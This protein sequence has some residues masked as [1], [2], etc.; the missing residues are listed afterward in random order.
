MEGYYDVGWERAAGS[1]SL[2]GSLIHKPSLICE[3]KRSSPSTG[4]IRPDVD[5]QEVLKEIA[6]GGGDAVSILTDPDN[7][8]GS[9]TDL[10][11]ASSITNLP[12]M[13]KDFVVSAKQVEAAW[14][15]GASGVL[16][17]Q[18]AFTRGLT[19]KD[20]DEMIGFAH[21]WGMEVLLEVYDGGLEEALNTDADLVGVNTRNLDTLEINLEKAYGEIR[22]FEPDSWR[23]VLESG[24]KS[25][26]D[27]EM[28][29]ELGVSKFLVGTAIMSAQSISSKIKE[30]KMG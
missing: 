22:K 15:S 13:M 4:I 21:D 14:R 30:L 10:R 29:M 7:F 18:P 25:R 19:E 11:S 1:P 5:L 9:L 17:I 16:L 3:V 26:R 8:M 12:T 24:V 23:I 20:L 2:V 6:M 27:I 28:F